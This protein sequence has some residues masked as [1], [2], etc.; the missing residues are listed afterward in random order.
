[1]DHDKGI[2]EVKADRTEVESI[3]KRLRIVERKIATI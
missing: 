1:M 3:D 2:D